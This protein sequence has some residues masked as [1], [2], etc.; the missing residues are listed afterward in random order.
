MTFKELTKIMGPMTVAR[1]KKY[2]RDREFEL[3]TPIPVGEFLFLI[4]YA[5]GVKV[6]A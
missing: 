5:K 1:G 6:H 4:R 3:T 2:A